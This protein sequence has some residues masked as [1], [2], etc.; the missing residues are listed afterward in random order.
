MA[1][2]VDLDWL[3]SAIELPS[4]VAVIGHP[5]GNLVNCTQGPVSGCLHR[6]EQQSSFEHT[7]N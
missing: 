5:V 4:Q 2:A 6:E 1:P 7:A 3:T